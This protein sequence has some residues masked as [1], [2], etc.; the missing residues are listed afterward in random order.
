MGI[1]TRKS[2]L[3]LDAGEQVFFARE[4]DY[5]KKNSYDAKLAELKGLQIVPVST[6]AGNGA[7]SITYRRYKGVGV[8][9]IIS[10]YANDFPR[11][12]VYGEEVTVKTKG[13]GDSYGYSIKEIRESMMSGKKLD[14]RRANTAR[15]AIEEKLNKIALLGDSEAGFNGLINNPDITEYTVP[16]DGTGS[17]KSWSTKTADQII[18]DV[19]G[20]VSAVMV[21]TYGREVPDTLALPLAQYNIIANTRVGD[22]EKTILQYIL[23]TSP[24]IK[25]IVWLNELDGAGASGTDRMMVL[26]SDSEHLSFELPQTFEQ[27]PPEAKGMSFDIV[28]H[29]E[30]AGTII[31]YPLSVAYGDG[32]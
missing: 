22:T 18:R 15:R 13:V 8:A 19:T 5:V 20:M 12:D 25:K 31:Y 4:L 32:I 17:A 11:V 23:A 6:E 14:V 7:T 27:F 10:D 9:K 24:A 30:T 29:A 21:P 1:E 26:C 28:C 2:P 16:A 3:H